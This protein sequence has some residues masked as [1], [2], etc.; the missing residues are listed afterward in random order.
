MSTALDRRAVRRG[1]GA[2]PAPQP[3]RW[4][5][6]TSPSTGFGA[7]EVAR[8]DEDDLLVLIVLAD[9][10]HDDG[11]GALSQRRNNLKARSHVTTRSAQ[12][13]AQSR[14]CRDAPIHGA[15]RPGRPTTSRTGPGLC[16]WCRIRKLVR[17]ARGAQGSALRDQNPCTQFTLTVRNR[18]LTVQETKV[19]SKLRRAVVI[20]S[21][22][23]GPA[24]AALRWSRSLLRASAPTCSTTCRSAARLAPE[25]LEAEWANSDPS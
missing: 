25:Q 22:P 12:V 10:A 7:Q 23:L 6:M 24:T 11:N 8:R 4:S 2:P 19:F 16:N 1:A 13:A 20:G 5:R 9:H 21:S 15:P 18:P 17:R 3:C 14:G